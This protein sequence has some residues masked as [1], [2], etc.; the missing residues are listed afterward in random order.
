MGHTL[1]YGCFRSLKE[2]QAYLTEHHPNAAKSAS[3]YSI[4]W[5]VY[6]QNPSATH[7]EVEAAYRAAGFNTRCSGVCAI[8]ARSNVLRK[9]RPKE[10]LSVAQAQRVVAEAR[11]A[12]KKAEA[13]LNRAPAPKAKAKAKAPKPKPVKASEPVKAQEAQVTMSLKPTATA[14][15]AGTDAGTPVTIH[16]PDGLVLGGITFVRV[17]PDHS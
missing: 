10:A 7:A 13:E 16:I 12:L 17:S 14:S 6:E 2:A 3:R 1:R 4:A 15:E 9:K 11:E 8:G 5:R